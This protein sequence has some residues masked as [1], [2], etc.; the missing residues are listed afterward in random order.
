MSE[1]ENLKIEFLPDDGG[2]KVNGQWFA[3]LEDY[4]RDREA[5]IKG[6]DPKASPGPK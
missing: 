5:K 2:V 1:E 4:Y 3:S 6:I